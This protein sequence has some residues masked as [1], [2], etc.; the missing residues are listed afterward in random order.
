[1]DIED[2]RD[3]SVLASIYLVRIKNAALVA[4]SKG[5]DDA[6]LKNMVN[7]FAYFSHSDCTMFRAGQISYKQFN[8]SYE[9]LLGYLKGIRSGEYCEDCLAHQDN[10]HARC[11]RH[12]GSYIDEL[13]DTWAVI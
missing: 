8:E 9:Q 6:T 1:M 10:G 13:Q 5:L 11:P 4:K 7:D 3:R 2:L 12:M